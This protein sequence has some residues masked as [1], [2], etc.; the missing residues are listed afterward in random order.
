MIRSR[1]LLAGIV[2][3]TVPLG[4]ATLEP[5]PGYAR[6]QDPAP[7]QFKAVSAKGNVLALSSHP[8]EDRAADLAFWSA[9]IEHQKVD[10]DGLK[11]AGRETV[12]SRGGVEGTLL[13]FE[14]GEGQGKL[15]YLVAV[16]VTPAR[17]FVVEATGRADD[18]GL[19]A[20]KLRTAM[21]SL[22]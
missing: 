8:N 4:C 6:L 5:P 22:R 1:M 13:H 10:V 7:Y 3:A 19:D 14:L 17:I 16:Y 15:A 20:D 18:L 11:L 12:R 9:A 21:Q 2:L